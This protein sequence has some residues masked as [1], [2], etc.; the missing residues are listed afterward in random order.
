MAQREDA[1]ALG[2]LAEM[3]VRYSK[4]LSQCHKIL[5]GFDSRW[6]IYVVADIEADW[7]HG[8]GITNSGADR[9]RILAVKSNVLKNISSIIEAHNP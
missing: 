3:V 1:V 6:H 4:R 7:T 8:G 2:N 9:I 5:C